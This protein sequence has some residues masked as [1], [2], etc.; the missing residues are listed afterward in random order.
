MRCV[1]WGDGPWAAKALGD[2]IDRGHAVAGVVLRRVS[3]TPVLRDAARVRGIDVI[4]PPDAH[5]EDVHRWV[6]DRRPDLSIS[7][8]YDQIIRQ[9][10]LLAAPLGFIN[11]HPGKLPWY[12]GRS[13]VNWAIVNGESEVGITVHVMDQGIDTG[14]ILL[15]ETVPIEWS[16][17]YASML[18]KLQEAVPP[19][20]VKAVDGLADGS[21]VP[22]PQIGLGSYFSV[23]R[24]G[25]ESI[26]WGASSLQI[27]N[28]IR[29]ISPPGP[30]ARTQL[31]GR[32]L[33][34]RSARFERDW[35]CYRSV[36]GEVVG[37][38]SDGV[39]IKTGDST[40]VLTSFSYADDPA[41]PAATLPVGVRLTP[42]AANRTVK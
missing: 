19:L 1:L 8:Q 38:E 7:I 30:C 34:V 16:D 6:A 39:R 25:D 12:R 24:D 23:R 28:L 15:Q 32:G 11:V 13:T 9:P 5:A 4:Q 20:L 33:I 40:I 29:A 18:A 42:I 17:T 2:L 10:L 41:A 27:Y 14:D 3:T 35:P 26:D 37:R 31:D 21:L 36:P 22:R